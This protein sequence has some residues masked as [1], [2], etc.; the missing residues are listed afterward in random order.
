M[1][2]IEDLYNRETQEESEEAFAY[3]VQSDL[4]NGYF[5]QQFH[6]PYPE[7]FC[8][9]EYW[10]QFACILVQRGWPRVQDVIGDMLIWWQDPNWSGYF[11]VEEFALDHRE[12][13]L[14]YVKKVC[15]EAYRQK[16]ASWLACLLLTFFPRKRNVRFIAD[17]LFDGWQ[18]F[19][20]IIRGDYFLERLKKWT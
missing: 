17:R 16:D 3:F 12:E 2:K 1:Y 20:N 19:S 5:L 10:E 18:N 8:H 13:I 14:P 6:E 11:T 15:L 4:P 7:P 9:K